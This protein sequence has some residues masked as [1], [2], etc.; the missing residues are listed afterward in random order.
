M[1]AVL[2]GA[3]VAMAAK[4]KPVATYQAFAASLGTGR[5]SIVNITID[6]WSTDE[7]R[8]K[9]LQTLQEFGPDKLVDTLQKIRP[10]VGFMRTPNSRGYTLYYAR[11]QPNPDGSRRVVV[12]TD[13]P[14]AFG[15][16]SN[17]TRSMQYRFTLVELH[18]DKDGKGDGKMVAAAKI[19][20]D[21]EAKKLEIENY[22]ALPVDLMSVTEKT[23]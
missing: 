7:E 1:V 15:E 10:T 16:A 22:N 8:E 18:L 6:R 21:K 11:L 4:A 2:V 3:A 5:S 23:P 13:R 17:N 9:L 14:V 12:A 19:S 20:W